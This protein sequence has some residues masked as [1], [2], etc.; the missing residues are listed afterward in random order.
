MSP[1]SRDG[2]DGTAGSTRSVPASPSTVLSTISVRTSHG[3]VELAGGVM[4]KAREPRV[5]HGVG[6]GHQFAEIVTSDA[7]YLD[8]CRST[9]RRG[10]I[11]Q[12]QPAIGQHAFVTFHLARAHDQRKTEMRTI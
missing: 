8:H 7:H 6:V 5:R 3:C 1:P 11:V 10:G 2:S 12:P 9:F 4:R